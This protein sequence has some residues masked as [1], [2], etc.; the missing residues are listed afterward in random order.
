M[1]IAEETN[2]RNI[3]KELSQ[4]NL[5][6]EQ[7]ELIKLELDNIY[8]DNSQESAIIQEIRKIQRDIDKT[9]QAIENSNFLDLFERSVY[10]EVAIDNIVLRVNRLLQRENI[11]LPANIIEKIKSHQENINSFRE[12][13]RPFAIAFKNIGGIS[14]KTSVAGKNSFLLENIRVIYRV[15]ESEIEII[16][17]L[18]LKGLNHISSA[19]LQS[20]LT[21]N[22][23]YKKEKAIAQDIKAYCSL[24]TNKIDDYQKKTGKYIKDRD[25]GDDFAWDN[26]DLL[27][28]LLL[29]DLIKDS[30]HNNTQADDLEMDEVIA[31]LG[32]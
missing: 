22:K 15:M 1:N 24:I 6:I 20:D 18:L 2:Y 19:I 25:F 28:N 3:N 9:E 23:A 31:R 7:L 17:L 13:F 21:S 30:E 32:G 12:R 29:T 16:P 27:Y 11:V 5:F 10:E 8:R 26:E 4:N 14:K